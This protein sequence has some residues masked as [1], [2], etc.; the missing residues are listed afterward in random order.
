VRSRRGQGQLLTTPRLRPHPARCAELNPTP[1]FSAETCRF[2]GGAAFAHPTRPLASRSAEVADDLPLKEGDDGSRPGG[3]LDPL[4]DRGGESTRTLVL[5]PSLSLLA[6]TP[7]ERAANAER[8]FRYR[9]VFSDE[10]VVGE[11][12]VVSTTSDLPEHGPA[13]AAP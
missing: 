11:D 2:A 1:A 4:S 12:A 8:A 9:A 10:T 7:R 6:Q 13:D 5:V 3:S